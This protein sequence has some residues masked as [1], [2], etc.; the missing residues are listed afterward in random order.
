MPSWSGLY[1]VVGGKN[2]FC[3]PAALRQGIAKALLTAASAATLASGH[4]ELYLHVKQSDAAAQKLYLG[5]GHQE[6]SKDG[7]FVVFKG[8]KPRILMRKSL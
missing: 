3:Y 4:K 2:F 6:V 5:G 1:S 7:G 8:I